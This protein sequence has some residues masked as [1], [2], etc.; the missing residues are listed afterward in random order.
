M[1]GL[2]LKP[3]TTA[4]VTRSIHCRDRGREC[5]DTGKYKS[6]L[7]RNKLEFV[8][9]VYVKHTETDSLEHT[10]TKGRQ[11]DQNVPAFI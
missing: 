2:T 7:C 1:P 9:R 8:F 6:T 10:L 5:R 4:C 11:A 3:A